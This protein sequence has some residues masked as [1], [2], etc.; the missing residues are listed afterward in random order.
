VSLALYPASGSTSI[1]RA[2]GMCADLKPR[3]AISWKRSELH[4]L[5]KQG[6]KEAR[7][8]QRDR[9]W[10]RFTRDEDRRCCGWSVRQ[11]LVW[12]GFFSA[13]A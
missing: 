4:S 9:K 11:V 1:V 8:E 2:C 13:I 12:G 3:S 10:K 5:S 7:A 6:K